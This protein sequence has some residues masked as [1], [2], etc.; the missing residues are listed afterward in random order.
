M[1]KDTDT[2]SKDL[3]FYTAVRWLGCE[4]LLST[5]FKFR[6]KIGNFLESK[7]KLQPFLSDEEWV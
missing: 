1:L 7:G 2:E 4:R 5:V 3:P 6:N